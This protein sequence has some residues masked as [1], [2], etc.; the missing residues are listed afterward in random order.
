MSDLCPPSEIA[1]W[2]INRVDRESGEAI[3]HLKL[4]KMVY[5]AQA[6]YLANFNKALFSEDIQAWAHGPVVP[7]LFEAYKNCSWNAIGPVA[8][9][10]IKDKDV[11]AYLEAAYEKFSK[12]GAKQ[13]EKMTHDHAPW[14]DARGDLPPEARCSRIIDK[15]AMRDF[16]A[17]KIE[18]SWPKKTLI[19]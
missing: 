1:K 19:R 12:F 18:K 14:R 16:Y 8:P 9:A 7:S 11:L 2:F 4:Q 13:L 3:T 6:Y 5:F 15:I 10:K 17:Q